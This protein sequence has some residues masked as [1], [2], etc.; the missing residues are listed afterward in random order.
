MVWQVAGSLRDTGEDERRGS[1]LSLDQW[2]AAIENNQVKR[3]VPLWN[4]LE[5]SGTRW[6]MKTRQ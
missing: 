3:I 2:V 5:L 1:P 6:E 4:D